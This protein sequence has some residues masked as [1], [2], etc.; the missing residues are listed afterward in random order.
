MET[1][2]S[3]LLPLAGLGG[4]LYLLMT[5]LKGLWRLLSAGVCGCLCLWL[6]NSVSGFTG[7]LFPVNPVTVAVSGFL[8][9]PG[10]AVLALSQLLL[11]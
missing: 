5:P 7:L 8:G 9:L 10:I 1:Y 2:L 11:A 3:L 4:V 6:L